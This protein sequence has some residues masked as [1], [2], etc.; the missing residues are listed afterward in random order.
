[1]L[2]QKDHPLDGDVGQLI[3]KTISEII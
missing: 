3:Q 1:M 2:L